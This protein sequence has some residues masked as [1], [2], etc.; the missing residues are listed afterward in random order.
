MTKYLSSLFQWLGITLVLAFCFWVAF[1][2]RDE[3]KFYTIRVYYKNELVREYK[4]CYQVEENSS[5]F[6]FKWG[7][8]QTWVDK[9]YY[10][11]SEE[12]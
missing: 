6:R 8:K 3:V 7:F 9:K 5:S 2:P 12:E 10:F 4:H 1:H 11:I